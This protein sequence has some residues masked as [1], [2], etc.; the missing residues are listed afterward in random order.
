MLSVILFFVI[1]PSILCVALDIMRILADLG[2]NIYQYY[3]SYLLILTIALFVLVYL[4]LV[5]AI[6][7]VFIYPIIVLI[8]NKTD[9]F[10]S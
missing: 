10:K 6:I 7:I 8:K 3:M 4:D 2:Y 9:I 1:L 5:C